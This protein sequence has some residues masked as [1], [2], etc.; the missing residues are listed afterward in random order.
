MITFKKNGIFYDN[1]VNPEHEEHVNKKVESII[2]YLA[3]SIEFDDNLTLRNFF[4]LLEPDE[5]MIETVFG[6]HLGH[7]SI[8]PYMD[9]VKQDCVPDGKEDLECIE[10]SWVVEQFDYAL[11]YE[12]HKND[13]EDNKSVMSVLDVDL[14]EPTEDDGNEVS[15]Y[16]YVHGWG[17]YEKS[18]DEEH[19]EDVVFP[20]HTS[21]GI[22][23]IPLQ[24]L[25]HL[26]V[27][28]NTNIQIRD[29]NEIGDEEPLV[30]GAMYF[31]VFDVV[32]AILSEISFCGTPEDRDEHWRGIVEDIDEAKR[33]I[34]EEDEEYEEDEDDEE[35][36]DDGE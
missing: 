31:N 30:E 16:I 25:A 27:R 1:N 21:Y 11:F 32:G 34:K 2:P 36:G 13:K 35:D 3:E 22:E 9:E 4:N 8:R 26:P 28:L 29:R 10:C 23:F 24:R 15:V 12:K 14:H 18:E 7:S 5:K 17:L 6:S 33:H 20:T 19:D